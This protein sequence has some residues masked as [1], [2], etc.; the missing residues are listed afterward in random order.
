VV[1]PDVEVL[2]NLLPKTPFHNVIT[3]KSIPLN[4]GGDHLEP[5]R[6]ATI[7]YVQCVI[8]YSR[9]FKTPLNYPKYKKN[10][11]PNAHVQVF[12]A[13]IK[14]NIEI[15]N[16]EITNLLN[17]TLRDN[18]FNWCNNYMR[19]NPNY[20][21]ADLEQAFCRQYQIMKMMNMYIYSLKTLNK[22]P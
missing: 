10:F 19:N 8:F 3:I 6:G 5:L 4:L 22:N 20:R 18:T 15:V 12:K 17:F 9:P 16:E 14:T 11:D 7:A 21:F 1:D 13:D 2:V